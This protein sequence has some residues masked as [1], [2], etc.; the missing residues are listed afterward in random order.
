MKISRKLQRQ[1]ELKI[2]HAIATGRLPVIQRSSSH[3]TDSKHEMD[4]TDGNG[5][6]HSK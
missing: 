2:Q 4:R 6:G 3:G 1:V 5:N